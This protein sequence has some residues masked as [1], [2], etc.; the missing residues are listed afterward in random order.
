[1]NKRRGAIAI[2]LIM[3][4]TCA[5]GKTPYHFNEAGANRLS[6]KQVN[7]ITFDAPIAQINYPGKQILPNTNGKPSLSYT[8]GRKTAIFLL[9][10]TL[11]PKDP[12]Q[13]MVSLS[14]GQLF[15]LHF[16]AAN[17]P[18]EVISV[19]NSSVDI[20]LPPTQPTWD[21]NRLQTLMRQVLQWGHPDKQWQRV[22]PIITLP[23]QQAGVTQHLVAAWENQHH[24]LVEWKLCLQ[25][26]TP[27]QLR[28]QAYLKGF[29]TF[30]GTRPVRQVLL[31]PGT[32]VY[33]LT[34]Q[35]SDYYKQWRQEQR[36]TN[37]PPINLLSPYRVGGSR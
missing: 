22:H 13:F 10:K 9:N 32:C 16:I 18:G 14:D 6:L 28:S 23:E 36:P 4:F 34:L 27:V 26:E 24:Q 19:T 12:V 37:D 33:L 31:M 25:T 1:M 2:C 30:L 15:S 3:P 7:A 11:K 8:A 20:H 29:C 21:S 5:L 35:D 17:T